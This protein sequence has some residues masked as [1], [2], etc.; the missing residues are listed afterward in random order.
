MSSTN[1]LERWAHTHINK[2]RGFIGVFASDK[3]P[4]PNEVEIPMACIANYDPANLSG[5][6]W[7]AV[8]IQPSSIYWFD[9][10]G[11]DAD[12]PDLL[13]GHQTHF[14]EWLSCLCQ[15]LGLNKYEYNRVD[16]QSLHETTC[17]LW[18]LYF[19]KYGPNKGWEAFGRDREL[20]DQLIRQLVRL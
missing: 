3:L 1:Q 19:V 2:S 20:N 6:H 10:Y 16:L 14:R 8:L 5:S 4:D 15:R 9:S 17:G 7:V 13:I 11:F 18:A 12:Q